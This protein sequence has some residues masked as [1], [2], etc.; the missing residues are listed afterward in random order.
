MSDRTG[1][2]FTVNGEVAEA[3]A[4]LTLAGWLE[5]LGRDPRTV[6]IERNGRLVP[7]ATFGETPLQAGDKLELVQFVQGG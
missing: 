4:G 7:R 3:P 1:I 5:L 2:S 6:A